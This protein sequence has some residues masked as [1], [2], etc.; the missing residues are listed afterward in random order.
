MEVRNLADLGP[1]DRRAFFDRDAGIE[2]VRDDVRDIVSRVR[3]EGDVAVREFCEEFDGVSVG[4]LDITDEAE[5]AY[6]EIDDETREAMGI[7]DSLIRLSVGVEHA[8][9]VLADLDRGLD[10]I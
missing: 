9:D 1:D 6:E 10:R 3:E 7:T 8:E 5:R 2:A 4:N